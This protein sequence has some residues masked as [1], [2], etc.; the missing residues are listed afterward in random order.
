[1]QAV[2]LMWAFVLYARDRRP[3]AFALQRAGA[4]GEAVTQP[5]R[6]RHP[7]ERSPG[8]TAMKITN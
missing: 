2:A 5:C 1:M 7:A 4:P 8:I 3:G 6:T